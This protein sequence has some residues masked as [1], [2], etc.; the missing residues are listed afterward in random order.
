[1]GF[2]GH[3]I[4]VIIIAKNSAATIRKCLESIFNQTYEPDEVVVVYGNSIDDTLK[5]VKQF[6]VKLF[7]EP[8]LGYG[9]ARNIGIQKAEGDIIFFIDSDCY[10]EPDWIEKIL[11]HFQNSDVAAVTGKLHLWN[12]EHACA[13]FL[14][15]VG[16]RMEMPLQ[17]RFVEIAPTMNLAIRRDLIS[18]IGEFDE[19]LVRGEDTDFT[20]R[21]T[22]KH[23]LL[24]EP[25]A[26]VWFRG[27]P[28][29]WAASRKCIN[30]F[31]G[32]GQ[33]FAKHGFKKQFVRFNLLVRGLMLIAAIVS[34]FTLPLYVPLAIL[35][36]LFLE[37]IYKT[38]KMYYKYR[39]GCVIYYAVFFTFWSLASLTIVYG[40]CR[41]L[42]ERRK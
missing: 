25:Q 26:V 23:K 19:N 37:F 20:Y 34:F 2:D 9:Y 41:G 33:L 15:Y 18:D 39:D 24:Y 42:G 12:H 29:V 1:M 14:A 40:L 17:H 28:N 11:P 36:V 3:R 21:L 27:S 13:R 22:R 32:V 5:I 35:A 30:H 4:S 38:V 16:G 31:I 10:A 6:P 7:S 8:G